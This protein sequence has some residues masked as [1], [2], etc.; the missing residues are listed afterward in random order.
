MNSFDQRIDLRSAAFAV[1]DE[2]TSITMF[3][4]PTLTKSRKDGTSDDLIGLRDLIVEEKQRVE[5]LLERVEHALGQKQPKRGNYTDSGDRN[6]VE[7]VPSARFSPLD[8]MKNVMAATRDL[9]LPNGNLSAELIA[10]LY[11]IS[12]S[13]LANWLGRT[14]QALS[15]TPDADS[16][17]SALGYFE[18]VA[19]LRVVTEN[20]AE[21]RKWLRMPNDTLGNRTPL[22]LMKAGRLQDV[23]DKVDDML[24]GM[25]T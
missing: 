18:R 21:F 23:A 17:Q 16:L 10:K 3:H 6:V 2:L 7:D 22:D 5:R 24:T 4:M 19:R 25:P 13:Q 11:G 1:D 14:K 9:R 20:D 12:L 15:K 8:Q